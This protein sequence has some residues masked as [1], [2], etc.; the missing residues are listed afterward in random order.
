MHPAP[1]GRGDLASAGCGSR[2][3]ETRGAAR[4]PRHCVLA[5]GV[6]VTVALC[7]ALAGTIRVMPLRAMPGS[8]VVRA[9]ALVR[10]ADDNPGAR[11]RLGRGGGMSSLTGRIPLPGLGSAGHPQRLILASPAIAPP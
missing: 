8:H 3:D 10:F 11:L 2:A 7:L 5:A 4:L 6:A 9:M 1:S